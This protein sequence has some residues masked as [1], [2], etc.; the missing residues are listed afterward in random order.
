MSAR[1]SVDADCVE[2]ETGDRVTV[3]VIGEPKANHGAVPMAEMEPRLEI[4]YLAERNTLMI[5]WRD[6]ADKYIGKL[7]DYF[8]ST[9][10]LFV[11]GMRPLEVR[12]D[13]CD[14]A[15]DV[16]S[17]GNI[18][19]VASAAMGSDTESDRLV[20][21]DGNWLAVD[22][23]SPGFATETHDFAVKIVHNADP[24]AA[25]AKFG[26]GGRPGAEVAGEQTT[27]RACLVN[28]AVSGASVNRVP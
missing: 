16:G 6:C 3:G 18:Q 12:V 13:C 14:D 21:A 7:P 25:A 2:V 11:I 9:D 27:C 20:G 24:E 8:N 4:D 5:W 19:G 1:G 15:I 22:G 26:A 17:F 10:D 28:L 23:D